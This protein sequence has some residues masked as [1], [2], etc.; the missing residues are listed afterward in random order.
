MQTELEEARRSPGTG[1]ALAYFY[2]FVVPTAAHMQS[3]ATTLLDVEL[4]P[5]GKLE[6]GALRRNELVVLVPRD[7]HPAADLKQLLRQSL[8]ERVLIQAKPQFRADVPAMHRPIFAYAVGWDAASRTCATLCDLPTIV[9]A[10]VDRARDEYQQLRPDVRADLRDFQN[11]LHQLVRAHPATRDGRVRIV[12][13]PRVGPGFDVR[14][15]LGTIAN[16]PRPM[17]QPQLLGVPLRDKKD[18]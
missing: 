8:D 12:S 16:M 17:Q 4:E 6:R 3:G 10:V 18:L 7:L 9:S 11:R 15:L 5:R 13:V 14:K 1:L 2:N